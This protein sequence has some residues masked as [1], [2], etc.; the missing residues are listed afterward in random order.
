[1]QIWKI[2]F[3]FTILASALISCNHYHGRGHHDRNW[4]GHR[5]I[6][7]WDG[8]HRYRNYRGFRRG[9]PPNN[10][11]EPKI[12]KKFADDAGVANFSERVDDIYTSSHIM[13]GDIDNFQ[14]ERINPLV[15]SNLNMQSET[16]KVEILTGNLNVYGKDQTVT[17]YKDK[18]S[19][20]VALFGLEEN[21]VATVVARGLTIRSIPRGVYTYDGT[22][23]V[24]KRGAGNALN[25]GDFN[26]TVDFGAR[27]GKLIAEN[28]I[29]SLTGNFAV[30]VA[31]G[32]YSGSELDFTAEGTGVKASIYG[33]F[34]GVSAAGVSGV[35]HDNAETP[36]YYGAI[37]GARTTSR[38]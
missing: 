21:N 19:G 7:Y 18:V 10:I 13:T 36:V 24:I 20:A 31:R 25:V 11:I 34:H 32:T 17:I 22:N 27:T 28:S 9:S 37:A 38:E 12:L 33:N 15:L 30:N 14:V 16:A 29:S 1:M 26:M 4:D 6:H 8:H 35:Y 2:L 3:A 23:A 5:T